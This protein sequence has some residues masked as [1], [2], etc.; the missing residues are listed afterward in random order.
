MVRH[1]VIFWRSEQAQDLI[2]YSLL[3]A[4]ICLSG[5]AFFIGM[6]RSTSAIWGTVNNRLSASNNAS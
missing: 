6:G 1:L 2:E 4:F 3:L 5:A